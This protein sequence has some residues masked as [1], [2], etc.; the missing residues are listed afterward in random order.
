MA[1]E[2][3]LFELQPVGDKQLDVQFAAGKYDTLSSAPIVSAFVTVTA[4][5]LSSIVAY[6]TNG[7]PAIA[8]GTWPFSA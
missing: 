4:P 7:F 1:S 3:A 8:L 5:L 6:L 2:T